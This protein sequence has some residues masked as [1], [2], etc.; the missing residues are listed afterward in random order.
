MYS[1]E[2]ILLQAKQ[3]NNSIKR[4]LP[5]GSMVINYGVKIQEF[6]SKIEILNCGRSGD[7]F[8]ELN[9]QEYLLFY[10]YGW[11]EGALRLA[12]QN[13]KRKLDLIENR[14]KAEVNTRK[15]DKHIQKLKTSRDNLLIKY[16]KKKQQ[17]IKTQQNGKKEKHL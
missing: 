11:K 12:L 13:Y 8:Q 17:L 14:M 16:A 1:V 15:N 10:K 7:F 9:E 3:D 5:N 2:D 6:P 4:T